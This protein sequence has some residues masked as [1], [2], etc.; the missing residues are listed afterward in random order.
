M[1]PSTITAETYLSLSKHN[2]DSGEILNGIP[3]QTYSEYE[4]IL[5][6]VNNVHFGSVPFT[7]DENQRADFVNNIIK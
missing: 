1:K 3:S 5:T 6:Q 2:I 4:E 7:K